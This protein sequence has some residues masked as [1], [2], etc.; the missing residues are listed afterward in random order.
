MLKHF[1]VLF[2]FLIVCGSCS[3]ATV[4]DLDSNTDPHSCDPDDLHC[5]RL[6]SARMKRIEEFRTTLLEKLDL[7][8]VPNI[9]AEDLPSPAMIESLKKRYGITEEADQEES[10][11]NKELIILA[12]PGYILIR[13]N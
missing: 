3:S 2:A 10:L 1:F 5:Q 6:S 11:S 8:S 9:S 4:H 12:K 7:D 13:T